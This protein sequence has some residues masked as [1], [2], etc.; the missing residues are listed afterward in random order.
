MSASVLWIDVE[1]TGLDPKRHAT[2][3]IG[4][5]SELRTESF[6]VR[7]PRIGDENWR[8]GG[9]VT[10][11]AMRINGIKLDDVLE[12][13]L[14]PKTAIE[15]IE[16]HLDEL[17]GDGAHR[18]F[19]GGHNFGS[20]D[21][22][23]LQEL[24]YQGHAELPRHPHRYYDS[25]VAIRLLVDAGALQA[26]TLSEAAA[27]MGLSVVGAHSA[28]VD[29]K[30]SA[31]VWEKAVS[32]LRRLYELTEAQS[33]SIAELE[34]FKARVEARQRVAAILRKAGVCGDA[35][36]MDTLVDQLLAASIR[37]VAA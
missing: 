3:E 24:A 22:R 4:L 36:A 27:E 1:T 18:V 12:Q 26:V 7:D 23:F 19:W 32:M 20:F 9:G 11:E 37:E 25:A 15:R 35:R 16:T 17:A 31:E 14:A 2:V 8:R 21:L 28:G 33:L 6:L 34:A 13:G 10:P 5:H 30:M 29:A